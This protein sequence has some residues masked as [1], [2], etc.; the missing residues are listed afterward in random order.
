MQAR[1]LASQFAASAALTLAAATG[2]AAP[3]P[4]P[5]APVLDVP[6]E[7]GQVEEARSVLGRP[8]AV[9]VQLADNAAGRAATGKA[10]AEITRILNQYQSRS[11]LSEMHS[12]NANADKD[13]VVVGDEIHALL[14]RALDLCRQ[15]GGAFDP[16]VAS[17]DYLWNFDQKPFVRPLP[18]E[19]AARRAIATCKNMVIKPNNTVRLMKPGMR[20]TLAGLATGFALERA[21]QV[22]RDANVENFRVQIGGAVYVQG[23][24]GT[25]HWYTTAPNSRRPGSPLAQLYLSSHAAITRSDSDRSVIRGNHRYHDVLDPRTGSPS[26]GV[27]QVTVIGTEPTVADALAYAAMVLGPRAGLELLQKQK[28]IEGFLVDSQGHVLATKGIADVA[29]LPARMELQ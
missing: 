14:Q 29:R 12:I 2:H 13:E 15:T 23:R 24:M 1:I 18:D 28:N 4:Q 3:P 17:Y 9:R 16:T 11:R 10:L 6:L 20:V 26:E 7:A 22:L 27:V 21:A 8:V 19:I 25:R 5:S